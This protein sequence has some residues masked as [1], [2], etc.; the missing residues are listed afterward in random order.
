MHPL[1]RL[2]SQVLALMGI[3][4]GHYGYTHDFR[5][6]ELRNNPSPNWCIHDP[7]H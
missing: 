7:P 1:G 5:V 4:D 6:L 2:V 3:A